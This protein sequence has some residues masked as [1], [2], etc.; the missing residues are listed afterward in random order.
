M[1]ARG[2]EFYP[3]LDEATCACL[4]ANTHL[5]DSNTF[6]INNEC[7]RRQRDINPA[8]KR[9]ST[10]LKHIMSTVHGVFHD[11]SVMISNVV[12]LHTKPRARH[13]AVHQDC[14]PEEEAFAFIV[15]I[16]PGTYLMVAEGSQGHGSCTREK[17]VKLEIPVGH[18][19]LFDGSLWHAGGG[20]DCPLR[21]HGMVYKDAGRTRKRRRIAYGHGVRGNFAS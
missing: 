1:H 10:A 5:N 9:E 20:G 2:Y 3:V 6:P 17:L 7:D 15:A 12:F 8:L 21:L 14:R 4:A 19:L 18:M 13:Q 11:G 16:K